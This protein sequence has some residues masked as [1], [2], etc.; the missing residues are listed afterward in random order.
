MS[1]EEL[2]AAA[3][4]LDPKARA[5]LAERLLDSLEQLSPEE[6]AR[7]WAEEAQR[8]EGALDAGSLSSR[9][10]GEVFRDAR[11]RT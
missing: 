3:L 4:K 8:R 6:N 2:E 1:I 11:A 9:S 10:A 5:R 7:I